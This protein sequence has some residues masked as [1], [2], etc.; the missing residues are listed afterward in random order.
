MIELKDRH[1]GETAWIVAKGPSVLNLT[2]ADIG[3]GPIIALYETIA[4]V[5]M[6]DLPNPVYSLQKDGGKNKTHVAPTTI[7]SSE[8]KSRDCEHCEW[9]VRPQKATLLLHDLEAEFCFPDY[10]PRYLF[11]LAEIGLPYNTFSLVC[12]LKIAQF[13]GCTKFMFV[14]ADA[15]AI[16]DLRCCL[17]IYPQRYYDHDY[18]AQ[19]RMFPPYLVGLDYGFVTPKGA[20]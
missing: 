8:C 10:S 15:Q 3:D 4:I 17:P 16:G 18:E 5:E 20:T 7:L 11:T 9:V 19:R 1:S 12:A 6:L 13:L 14:S 2:R